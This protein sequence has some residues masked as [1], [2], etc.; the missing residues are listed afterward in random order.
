[1]AAS[2]DQLPATSGAK[3]ARGTQGDPNG[4]LRA[5]P[6][7][8]GA[9]IQY[10]RN[11]DRFPQDTSFGLY[12]PH[13]V[14]VDRPEVLVFSCVALP[15]CAIPMVISIIN[16]EKQEQKSHWGTRTITTTLST[17]AATPRASKS[18][19]I[20]FNSFNSKSSKHFRVAPP[21]Q[22]AVGCH[23]ALRREA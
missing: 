8:F 22:L 14:Q 1:M 5:V 17:A 6:S 21:E 7:C 10:D 12:S 3:V 19:S 16:H 13:H 15:G 4:Y 18:K 2:A 23:N 11:S 20:S 9:Q